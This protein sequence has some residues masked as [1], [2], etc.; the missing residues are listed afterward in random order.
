MDIS[1]INKI[2]LPPQFKLDHVDAFMEVE[3]HTLLVI[4]DLDRNFTVTAFKASHFPSTVM[5][6]F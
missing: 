2:K 3:Q 6:L 5:F 1:I 4:R